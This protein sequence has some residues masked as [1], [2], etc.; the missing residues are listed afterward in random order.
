MTVNFAFMGVQV[1]KGHSTIWFIYQP[2]TTLLCYLLSML[3]L[4]GIFFKLQAD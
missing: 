1:P 2:L 3:T 4:I